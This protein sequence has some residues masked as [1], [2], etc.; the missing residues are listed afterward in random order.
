MD[1]GYQEPLERFRDLLRRARETDLQEPAAMT[2]A[3]VGADGRLSARV[4]LL[5]GFDQRGFVFYTNLNSDKSQQLRETG[6]ASLCFHWDALREQVRIEGMAEQ[7]A[8]D[9]ADEY[10]SGRPRESQVAAW[11]SRQSAELDDRATLAKRVTEFEQQFQGRDVPRPEFWSGFR[12]VPQRIE[13][14]TGLPA[15]LH[16]RIVFE[17]T[18]DGW[19]KR[20]LY[21]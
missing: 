5:R 17:R 9:E 16:D 19:T 11:A 14:W 4:V 18:D 12:I 3:T 8:D 21:P 10:W 6:R 15:R 2:L 1:E 13:F 7:V 20:L